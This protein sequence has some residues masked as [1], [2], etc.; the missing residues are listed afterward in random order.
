MNIRCARSR[1]AWL[2]RGMEL[3]RI[4]SGFGS[5]LAIA[6]PTGLRPWRAPGLL[7]DFRLLTKLRFGSEHD[8]RD[9]PMNCLR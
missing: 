7:R 5:I 3:Q 4:T 6:A 9:R 8:A 1:S 2:L